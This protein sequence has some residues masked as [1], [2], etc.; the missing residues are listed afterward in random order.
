MNKKFGLIVEKDFYIV[1]KLPS[2]RFL[3]VPDNRN[4]AIKTRNGRR[5]QVW[6]FHQQ[7]L[8][9]RTRVNNQSWDIKSAGK[10]NDMQIWSTNSGWFQVF[11]YEKNQFI[12]WT[13]NKVLE[14]VGSKDEEGA[15][16]GVNGNNNGTNQKWQ[17]LYVDKADKVE[18]KGLNEE[19]GFMINK[20]FY[21]VSELP[22]N[23]V[24]TMNGG[25]AWLLQR[26]WNN[27]IKLRQ[28]WFFDEKTKTIRNN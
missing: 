15:K 14:V 11:K 26:R 3:E 7:S 13:N 20:P 4:M 24:A 21:I 8:T 16:V 1:S 19:F 17:V 10:T 27:G 5:Q 22:F 9:I 18:T 25:N 12:N 2:G 6:Y 23:R 28:Q